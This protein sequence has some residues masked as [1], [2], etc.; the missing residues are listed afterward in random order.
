MPSQ[1]TDIAHTTRCMPGHGCRILTGWQTMPCCAVQADA[2]PIH[3]CL[4]EANIGMSRAVNEAV[5]TGTIT[6]ALDCKNFVSCTLLAATS[7]FKTVVAVSAIQ[8]IEWLERQ[9]I[10]QW[11]KTTSTY[12]PCALGKA[13]AAAGLKPQQALVVKKVSVLCVI[14]ACKS[15]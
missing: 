9:S 14:C 6:T 5:A 3:S 10:I 7:D 4:S 8:S 15:S 11:S 1:A 2:N 12:S 13:T